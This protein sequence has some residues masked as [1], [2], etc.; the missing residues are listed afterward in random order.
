MKINMNEEW[1]TVTK[2]FELKSLTLDEKWKLFDET[3]EK[4]KTKEG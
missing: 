2:A 4:D 1:T 3:C